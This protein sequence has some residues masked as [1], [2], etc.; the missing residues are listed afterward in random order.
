MWMGR[1]YSAIATAE[2][3]VKNSHYL[4]ELTVDAQEDLR[5]VSEERKVA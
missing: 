2:L 4:K 1:R 3:V 5:V